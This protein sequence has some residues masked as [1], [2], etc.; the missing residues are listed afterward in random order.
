MG[1]NYV[2]TKVMIGVLILVGLL[3]LVAIYKFLI[4]PTRKLLLLNKEIEKKEIKK[5]GRKKSWKKTIL[6]PNTYAYRKK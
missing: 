4:K 1:E 5:K 3:M 6:T 2:M